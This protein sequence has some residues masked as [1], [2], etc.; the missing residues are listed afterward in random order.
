MSAAPYETAARE[1]RAIVIHPDRHDADVVRNADG[2][3]EEAVSL[4]AANGVDVISGHIARVGLS[5]PST[6]FGAG[7]VA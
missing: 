7:K 2:M 1:E 5:R 3:L 6:L 4:V